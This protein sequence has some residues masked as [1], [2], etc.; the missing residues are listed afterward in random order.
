M[1]NKSLY[2]FICRKLFSVGLK[3]NS[4]L[5]LNIDTSTSTASS[6]VARAKQS[7]PINISV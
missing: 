3:S 1:S 7:V 5:F 4:Y 6:I 2:N